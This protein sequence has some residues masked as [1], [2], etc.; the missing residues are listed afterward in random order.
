MG[1][2][3]A[4]GRAGWA[5]G[6]SRPCRVRRAS[7]PDRPLRCFEESSRPRAAAF[8][9][10]ADG[11]NGGDPCGDAQG[12]PGRSSG[13]GDVCG[14]ACGEGRGE[15]RGE[16]L[17]DWRG[18]FP[19]D[20][21][22]EPRRSPA[23]ACPMFLREAGFLGDCVGD[24][25]PRGSL[26]TRAAASPLLHSAWCRRGLPGPVAS[27]SIRGR[28]AEFRSSCRRARSWRRGC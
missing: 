28:S 11:D 3:V 21:R 9:L 14:D 7:G 15:A 25:D 20:C 24:H 26:R 18:E 2:T 22:G 19:G 8:K 23:R 6:R 4:G 1:S 12:E 17:G 16:A 5:L 27:A 10:D 13:I